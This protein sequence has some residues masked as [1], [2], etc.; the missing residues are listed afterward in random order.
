VPALAVGEPEPLRVG[1][2]R[3]GAGHLV[4]LVSVLPSAAALR[5]SAAPADVALVLA[6]WPVALE[7]VAGAPPGS[8]LAGGLPLLLVGGDPTRAR[9]L[10][11]TSG[12]GLAAALAPAASG[13]LVGPAEELEALKVE[14][15]ELREAIEARKA[16]ERAKGILMEHQGISEREAFARIQRLSM[17]RRKPMREISEAIILSCELT[18]RDG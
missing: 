7:W 12:G 2:D 18:G 16:I 10:I 17:A 8:P 6:P 3:L 11:E 15:R 1:L 5:L 4:E 13:L 9:L 14:N